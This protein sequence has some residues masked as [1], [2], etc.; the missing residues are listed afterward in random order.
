MQKLL[1]RVETREQQSS[2]MRLLKRITIPLSKT[3]PGYYVIQ[4][5]LK[6]FSPESTKVVIFSLFLSCSLLCVIALL[7]NGLC[8]EDEGLQLNCMGLV[9]THL[10]L[11][12]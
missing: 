3:Q 6:H 1:E 8:V 10:A 5:C 7:L 11:E 9:H 2:F 4:V 12:K